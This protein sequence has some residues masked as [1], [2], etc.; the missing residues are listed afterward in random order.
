[1]KEQILA[2]LKKRFEGRCTSK[3]MESLADRLSAKITK[4][5]EIKGVIDELENGVI[6]ITDLQ[7]EGDRRATEIQN[8]AKELE[9]KIAEL[10]KSKKKEPEPQPGA[11]NYDAQIKELQDKLDLLNS[12]NKKDKAVSKLREMA[13]V[14]KIS[15]ILLE[16]VNIEDETQVEAV[17]AELEGKQAKLK[18]EMIESG[19]IISAPKKGTPA[20]AS[21][22]IAEQIKSAPIVKKKKE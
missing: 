4:E 16:N 11:T 21:S 10:E 2:E 22:E 13:K 6:K 18:Q 17:M 3:F 1:M 7:A 9:L 14:K 12:T 5:E 19:D 8:K 20:A 15:A